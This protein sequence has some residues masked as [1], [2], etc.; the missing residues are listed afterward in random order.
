MHGS[1]VSLMRSLIVLLAVVLVLVTK[2]RNDSGLPAWL[3]PCSTA[4]S[5][6][7]MLEAAKQVVFVPKASIKY[8]NLGSNRRGGY[9]A[10]LAQ[11]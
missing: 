6:D 2:A 3:V 5:H 11:E 1:S 8:A 7:I 4:I 10:A 9:F